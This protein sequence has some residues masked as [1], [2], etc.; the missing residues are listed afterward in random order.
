MPVYAIAGENS[1]IPVPGVLPRQYSANWLNGT[2]T[3]Y[4]YPAPS[5]QLADA[6]SDMTVDPCYNIDPSDLSFTFDLEMH[7]RCITVNNWK[8]KIHDLRAH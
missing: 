7:F 1:S 4:N 5:Q 8:L 2:R 6:S 3:I